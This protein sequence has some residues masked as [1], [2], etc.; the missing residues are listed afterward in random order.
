LT[1]FFNQLLIKTNNF[2]ETRWLG[3]PIWQNTMDLWTTQETLSEVRPSLLIECGTNRG[4]SALFYANLFDLIGHGEVLTIDVES[5]HDIRHPRIQ[6][7]I[8]SSLEPAVQ[9]TVRARVQS[10]EGPVMVILDSDHSCKHVRA[11]MEAFAP[12]VTPGSYLHVQDGVIDTHFIFGRGRPGPLPAIKAFIKAHPE[13]ELDGDRSAR[14][15]I[16]N[17]PCGWLRRRLAA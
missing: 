1:R 3:R 17:H 16:T 8:G 7:L 11:E 2:S 5:L 14:F 6:F 13:F 4:G 10:V 12:F 15:L 9:E